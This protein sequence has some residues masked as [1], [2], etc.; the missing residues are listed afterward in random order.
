MKNLQGSSKCETGIVL[1]KE[2]RIWNK[3]RRELNKESVKQTIVRFKCAT[4]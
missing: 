2:K 4:I 3:V 1:Y